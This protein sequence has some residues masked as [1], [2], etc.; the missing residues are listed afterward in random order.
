MSA[1]NINTE[2]KPRSILETPQHKLSDHLPMGELTDAEL[3]QHRLARACLAHCLQAIDALSE[4]EAIDHAAELMDFLATYGAHHEPGAGRTEYYREGIGWLAV[5]LADR[6][7][8]VGKTVISQNLTYSSQNANMAKAI[9]SGRARSADEQ[10]ILE[11]RTVF[12]GEDRT[13]WV[14]AIQKTI[15]EKGFVTTSL[16]VPTMAGTGEGGH[17]VLVL[18]V[19]DGAV[20]YFDPDLYALER[21]ERNGLPVP[22]IT[23]VEGD[24]RLF[25][26]QP[27]AAFTQR[28]SGEVLHIFLS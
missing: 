5:P 28:M 19:Q 27:V 14:K 16:K 15:D 21:Y 4:S 17:T 11:D 23:R 6:M 2:G 9:E 3:M 13:Q 1:P 7:R 8:S 24:D 10:H 22:E 25:Y 12:G 18:G 26:E 20:K